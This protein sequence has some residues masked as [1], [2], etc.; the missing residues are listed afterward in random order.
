MGTRPREL[1]MT[2]PICETCG[3]QYAEASARPERCPVCEDERQFV[4][5]NGQTWTT[6]EA[7]GTGHML[8]LED[9]DGPLGIGLEPAFA[10]S[11]AARAGPS[12][13]RSS[14]T[15]KS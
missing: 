15:L 1:G 5:W 8:R 10:T 6:R 13:R 4:R 11:S 2:H 7:L 14:A 9:D 12:M 3:T